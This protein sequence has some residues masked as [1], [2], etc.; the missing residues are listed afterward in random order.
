MLLIIVMGHLLTT[1]VTGV[2]TLTK[3]TQSFKLSTD[4]R[5]VFT[6]ITNVMLALTLST[7][8][9]GTFTLSIS[10]MEVVTLNTNVTKRLY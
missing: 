5:G 6:A 10:V 1:Y 7:D 2:F 4:V 9:T 3:V 8:L